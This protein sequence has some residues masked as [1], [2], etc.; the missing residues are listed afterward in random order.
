MRQF[1]TVIRLL[2]IC[3]IGLLMMPLA[4]GAAAEGQLFATGSFWRAVTPLALEER[5]VALLIIAVPYGLVATGLL[6]LASFCA[7]VKLGRL[8]SHAAADGLLQVGYLLTAGVLLL[9]P[10]RLT[11]VL[12]SAAPAAIPVV[13]PAVAAAVAIGLMLGFMIML[14]ARILAQSVT[15]HEEN[16]SFI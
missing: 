4:L 5:V 11:V 6:R 12:L 14:F 13:N 10:A 15:C 8:F 9:I 3:A 2:A 7:L 16:A 1:A